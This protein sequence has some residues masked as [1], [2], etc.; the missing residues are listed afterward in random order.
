MLLPI[1]ATFVQAGPVTQAPLSVDIRQRGCEA[2]EV[3]HRSDFENDIDNDG[4][5]DVA[6]F[7]TFRHDARGNEVRATLSSASTSETTERRFDAFD[8]EVFSLREQ[9]WGNDGVDSRETRTSNYDGDGRLSTQDLRFE[10]VGTSSVWVYVASYTYDPQG[11]LLLQQVDLDEGDDGSLDAVTTTTYS[12]DAFGRVLIRSEATDEL[13]DGS[14]DELRVRTNTYDAEGRLLSRIDRDDYD[15]DGLNDYVRSLSYVYDPQGLLTSH[16]SL[17]DFDGDGAYNNRL[18]EAYTYDPSGNQL[19]KVVTADYDNDGTPNAITT[20]NSTY[21]VA[22]NRVTYEELS[23]QDADGDV[24]HSRRTQA[25]YDALNRLATETVVE[26]YD[27][28]GPADSTTVITYS[29][30]TA[31]TLLLK[32]SEVDLD[33]NGVV[34]RVM[35]EQNAVEDLRLNATRTFQENVAEMPLSGHE[36]TLA[37]VLGNAVAAL[38]QGDVGLAMRNV[39]AFDVIVGGLEDAS[40]IT[41]EEAEELHA[42]V[43]PLLDLY[44]DTCVALTHE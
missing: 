26:E 27:I 9:D 41:A 35:T 25:T 21:D 13:A 22:G 6:S 5:V 10:D 31:G 28:P 36:V 33:S 40:I 44:R 24:E 2:P 32:R 20:I 18:D 34:N 43:M 23:D 1:L 12:Y 14:I 38:E 37:S 39:I 15:N 29:W 19:S 8:R 16:V 7:R 11:N 3:I 4:V 42:P 30:S 17:T